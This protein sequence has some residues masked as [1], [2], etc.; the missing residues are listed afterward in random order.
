MHPP[1]GVG[2]DTQFAALLVH[3]SNGRLHIVVQPQGQ[4]S[5]HLWGVLVYIP[6]HQVWTS[7]SDTLD[8]LR[9]SKE[10]CMI[11]VSM[12]TKPMFSP[13]PKRGKYYTMLPINGNP[14]MDRGPL[15][16]FGTATL[17]IASR[18]GHADMA[19]HIKLPPCFSSSKRPKTELIMEP[20]LSRGPLWMNT[21]FVQ[22]NSSSEVIS[23]QSGKPLCQELLINMG[24]PGA[25]LE[26]TPT[27]QLKLLKFKTLLQPKQLF[28]FIS[29]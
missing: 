3:P 7:L 4:P 1:L 23:G 16:A 2:S 17:P 24:V 21:H 15:R 29:P 25:K 13:Q 27:L 22:R 28:I 5:H 20:V 14:D 10:N 6:T 26:Y 19:V 11:L 9:H 8:Y 18:E 12:P